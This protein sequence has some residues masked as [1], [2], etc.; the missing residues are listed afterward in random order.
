MKIF[1][2]IEQCFTK[3]KKE[4]KFFFFSPLNS[5]KKKLIPNCPLV[6]FNDFGSQHHLYY[7]SFCSGY[8]YIPIYLQ[9]C[10]DH[11]LILPLVTLDVIFD[12]IYITVCKV[13]K[14][15]KQTFLFNSKLNISV[16]LARNSML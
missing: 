15:T 2:T 10:E 3:K 13:K 11:Q 5:E 6:I 8:H 4:K 9:E 14:K 7:H 12:I 1:F 16:L